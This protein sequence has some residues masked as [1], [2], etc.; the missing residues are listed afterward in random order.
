MAVKNKTVVRKKP[1]KKVSKKKELLKNN[2]EANVPESYDENLVNQEISPIENDI[3]YSWA[4][5]EFLYHKKSLS[6]HLAVYSVILLLVGVMFILKQWFA[7][8][9]FL[10]IA[11]LIYQYA[12]VKP[13]NVDVAITRL[14]IMVGE[15]FYPFSEIRVFWILYNPPLKQLNF[16]LTKRFSPVISVSLKGVDSGS[17]KD[18]LSIN[19][20][21]DDTRTEDL[22]DRMIRFIR[23]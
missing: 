18:I 17:V 15:K 12:E 14:G 1:V 2:L 20:V 3:I 11:V 6:W 22:M 5:P 10:L 9:V 19:I 4:A 13:R 16:E 8:P 21:E 23:F 7:I